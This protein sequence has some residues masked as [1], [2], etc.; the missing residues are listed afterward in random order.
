[1]IV[2]IMGEGQFDVADVDL[3]NIDRFRDN[4]GW[5]QFD[6]L[7]HADP[8]HWTEESDGKGFWA[9]TK[10]DD[11]WA[12]D[13]DSETFTSEKFVNL[14]D[15]DDDLMDFR[16]SMLETDGARHTALRKLIHRAP[17]R[18][19]AAMR[20]LP[21]IVGLIAAIFA[22][23]GPLDVLGA[24]LLRLIE[25]FSWWI[26]TIAHGVAHLPVVTIPANPL[27]TLLA[28]AWIIAGLLY[29]RPWLTLA[30]TLAG[31]AWLGVAAG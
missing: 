20:W 6:A 24:G 22:Q 15:V 12:V 9:V 28:Y 19:G 31:I 7:R 29:H 30:L 25:P 5:A 23:L 2:R 4:E 8:V 21:W 10:Y 13:K 18:S 3:S 14:E 26:N 27:F 11:I 17:D 16:R 1:M